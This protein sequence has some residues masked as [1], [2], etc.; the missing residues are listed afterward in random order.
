MLQLVSA[1]SVPGV[2]TF[3]KDITTSWLAYDEETHDLGREAPLDPPFVHSQTLGRHS[4]VDITRRLLP[5]YSV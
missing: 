5:A 4:V 1:F 2:S 3:S